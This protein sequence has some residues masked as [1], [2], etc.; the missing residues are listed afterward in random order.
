MTEFDKEDIETLD[1]I[2]ELAINTGS[3]V[4]AKNL[5]DSG[6]IIITDKEGYHTLTPGFDAEKEFSRYI[7]I[8]E[9]YRVCKSNV[10][11][12]GKYIMSNS[13]T[14][15]FQKLGGF[16]KVYA[17]LIKKE[18]KESLEIKK[19][20]ID[21]ELSEK[22]LNEYSKTKWFARIGFLLAVALVIFEIVKFIIEL[23]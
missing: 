8:L 6:K 4:S 2:V 17:D 5:I 12:G 10:T 22:I 20:K 9:S 21:L 7:H 3:S 11:K 19:T 16:K 15:Q 1:C 23:K 14:L 18:E 13:Y